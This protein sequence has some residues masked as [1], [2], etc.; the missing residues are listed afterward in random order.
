MDIQ[1]IVAALPSLSLPHLLLL[2]TALEEAIQ[3]HEA[4]ADELVR[5]I[6]GPRAL[7]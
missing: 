1:R 2:Q 6:L 7:G 3:R 4:L 5:L